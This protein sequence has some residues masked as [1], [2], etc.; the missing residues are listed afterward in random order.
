MFWQLLYWLEWMGK[1][2]SGVIKKLFIIN[3]SISLW[4]LA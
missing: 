4:K 1:Y 3:G 2:V